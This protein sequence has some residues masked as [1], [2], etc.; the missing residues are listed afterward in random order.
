MIDRLVLLLLV[1]GCLLFGAILIV[2]LAP[3]GAEDPVVAQ[4]ARSDAA[5]PMARPQNPRPEELVATALARPLFSS[6]RRPPQDAPNGAAA[7]DLGDAR[8]TGIVT[9][10]RHRLA[11]FALSGDKP[12]KVAEGDAVS[13]WRIESITPREVSLSG[14]SGTK[15]LQPKLDPNLAPPPVQPPIGQPGGRAPIPP[16]AGRPRMP[17]PGVPPA[18]AQPRPGVPAVPPGTLPRAARLRQQR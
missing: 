15:T 18:L 8:L 11:I 6:T 9:T 12:L 16:A 17:V 10:P 13:G 14:P 5:S 7:D 1:G 2:E 3:A 4:A